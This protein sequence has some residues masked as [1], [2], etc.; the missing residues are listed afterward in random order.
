[1]AILGN[2]VLN[3]AGENLG[4]IKEIMVD[5]HTGKVAYLVLSFGG[6]L[7]LGSK[8]FPVPWEAFRTAPAGNSL[9]LELDKGIL[10]EAPG[11][12]L[13]NWPDMGD[14]DWGRHIHDHYGLKWP[15][16]L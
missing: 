6:F 3:L 13:D 7:G 2:P 1:V 10:E 5:V 16:G 12:D 11:F 4:D 8:L 14:P 9:V 15:Y